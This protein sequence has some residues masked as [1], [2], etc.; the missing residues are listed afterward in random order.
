[1]VKLKNETNMLVSESSEFAIVQ[2]QHISSVDLKGSAIRLIERAGNLQK[3]GFTC[4]TSAYNAHH[5]TSFYFEMNPFQHVHFAKGLKNVV[6]YEYFIF[7]EAGQYV[8]NV[9]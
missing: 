2:A 7:C 8:Y 5:C 6:R 4:P 3:G 9:R 1:M